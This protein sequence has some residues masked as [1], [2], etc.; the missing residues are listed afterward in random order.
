MFILNPAGSR[1]NSLNLI[2]AA[3]EYFVDTWQRNIFKLVYENPLLQTHF[4]GNQEES[5]NYSSSLSQTTGSLL[6]E[7]DPEAMAWMR[8]GGFIEA[9]VRCLVAVICA[10]KSTN[11]Q[12]RKYLKDILQRHGHFDNL[13]SDELIQ[14]IPSQA[15]LLYLDEEQA[16]QGLKELLPSQED[17]KQVLDLAHELAL[18][19]TKLSGRERQYLEQIKN[20]LNN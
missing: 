2:N 14:I 7:P 12:E 16:L 13:D 5:C 15:Y 6:Q 3:T 19:D 17:R 18:A 1:Q 4:L 20:I 10:D 11:T 8:Q 9:T